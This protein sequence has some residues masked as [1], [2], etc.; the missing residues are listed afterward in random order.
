VAR[1]GFPDN[2]GDYPQD[3]YPASDPTQYANYG[4]TGGA[5]YS[6][7]GPPTGYPGTAGP[8]E[9]YPDPVPPPTPWFQRPAALIGL[10]VLSAAMLALLVYAVVTFTNAGT[11]Q[12]PAVTSSSITATTSSA[13]TSEAVP[14]S[15]TTTQTAAP[16]PSST[17]APPPPPTTVTTTVTPTT[18]AEPTTTQ[19]PTPS[20]TT[21]I[22]TSVTTVTETTTKPVLPTIP[23]PTLPS[24]TLFE[25]APEG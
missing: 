19:T 20:T 21:T 10:G 15:S 9:R 17:A 11:S 1:N 5:A 13:P 7:Y 4:G 6:E 24:P 2:P 18:T 12:S 25:P 8:T 3:D 23:W 22:S 14:P 16:E